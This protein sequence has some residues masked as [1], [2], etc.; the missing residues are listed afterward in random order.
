MR[1]EASDWQETPEWQETPAAWQGEYRSDEPGTDGSLVGPGIG[2][3]GGGGGDENDEAVDG[4]VFSSQES[5]HA[6]ST[7]GVTSGPRDISGTGGQPEGVYHGG[8]SKGT[9][10]THPAVPSGGAGVPGQD[11]QSGADSDD[12]RGGG[13]LGGRGG[14]GGRGVGGGSS[15]G[16]GSGSSLDQT[17]AD[18]LSQWSLERLREVSKVRRGVLP[19]RH[20]SIFVLF[21]SVTWV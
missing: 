12:R 20:L 19:G 3:G 6:S 15:G 4:T 11:S 10:A 7:S 1:E 21:S 8:D 18:E 17:S 2:G 5:A 14:G 16:G 13:R 9:V